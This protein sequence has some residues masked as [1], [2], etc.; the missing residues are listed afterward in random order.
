MQAYSRAV[1][2]DIVRGLNGLEALVR[3]HNIAGVYGPLVQLIMR[4]NTAGKLLLDPRFHRA[5]EETARCVLVPRVPLL[6]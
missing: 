2:H 5:V 6:L 4:R 3:D 1:P